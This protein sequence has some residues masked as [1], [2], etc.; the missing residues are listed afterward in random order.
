M[1]SASFVNILRKKGYDF[2]SGVPCTWLAGVIK[3]LYADAKMQYVAAPGEAAAVGIAAGAYL[4]GKTPAVLMQNHGLVNCMDV[5]SS[6]VQLYRI[7]LL[8]LVTWRGFR[9]EDF[10]EHHAVGKA[11]RGVLKSF[12]VPVFAPE[13]D[14]VEKHLKVASFTSKMGK[15]P[16]VLLLR[17]GV[18]E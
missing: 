10:E 17:K 16:V 1:D 5:V 13:K 3:A 8:M 18:I 11:T 12:G 6:L 2:V 15:G 9:S 4:G 7:P 14:A